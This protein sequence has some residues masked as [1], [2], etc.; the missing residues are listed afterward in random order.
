MDI[1]FYVHDAWGEKDS[2]SSGAMSMPGRMPSAPDMPDTPDMPDA[3]DVPGGM[4]GG[5]SG[6]MGGFGG[7]TVDFKYGDAI[8]VRIEME[9]GKRLNPA[10]MPD[11]IGTQGTCALP[12]VPVHT[13]EC[14]LNCNALDAAGCTGTVGTSSVVVSGGLGAA[15]GDPMVRIAASLFIH[16]DCLSFIC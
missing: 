16:L 12:C 6:G 2:G 9:K 11:N 4:P 7:P 8:T 1:Y 10:L 15:F 13:R 5:M 14:F 3:P